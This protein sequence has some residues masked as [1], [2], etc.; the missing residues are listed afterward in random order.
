MRLAV[1]GMV[2]LARQLVAGRGG[3]LEVV[4]TTASPE[5]SAGA[6]TLRP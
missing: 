5:L 4:P 1:V 6:A 3:R 2:H